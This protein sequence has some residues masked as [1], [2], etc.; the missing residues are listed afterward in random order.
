MAT[1]N[2]TTVSPSKKPLTKSVAVSKI[3]KCPKKEDKLEAKKPAVRT[4]KPLTRALL[5]IEPN[6][7][8][9]K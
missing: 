6:L 8:R 5:P 1:Q 2:A 9:E 3:A 4:S 7:L